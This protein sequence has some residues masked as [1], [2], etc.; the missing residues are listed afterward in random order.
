MDRVQ[1]CISSC[2]RTLLCYVR[3]LRCRGRNVCAYP[4]ATLLWVWA[5]SLYAYLW[6][7]LHSGVH[8]FVCRLFVLYVTSL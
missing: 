4:L 5:F 2:E 1:V 8:L 3:I 6:N 7:D